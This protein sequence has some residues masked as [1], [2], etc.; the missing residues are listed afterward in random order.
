[1]GGYAG[2][3]DIGKNNR[4]DKN[5]GQRLSYKPEWPELCTS[6]TG[7]KFSFNRT[8]YHTPERPYI[9]EHADTNHNKVTP[10]W[11]AYIKNN[12]IYKFLPCY[13]MFVTDNL[14]ENIHGL[15]GC[16]SPG[17]LLRPLNP[18]LYH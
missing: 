3:H 4:K 5:G 15:Y 16:F 12:A 13:S 11:K 10:G 17:K 14:M 1:M 6:P 7:L 2:P 18:L 8:P 9:S